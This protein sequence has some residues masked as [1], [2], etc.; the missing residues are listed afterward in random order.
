[1]V[2]V[3]LLEAMDGKQGVVECTFVKSTVTEAAYFATP[4][5][6]GK[7]GMEENLGLPKLSPFEEKHLK[8]VELILWLVWRWV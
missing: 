4:V 7:N 3:Q 6:L 8:E 5:R 1:M 2:F